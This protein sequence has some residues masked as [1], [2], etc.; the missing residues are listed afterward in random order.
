MVDLI[1]VKRILRPRLELHEG[2]RLKPY[3]D[4]R[5]FLTIGIGRNLDIKGISREEAD[6]LLGND[7]V[8]SI[9]LVRHNIPWSVNLDPQR[10]SVLVEMAFQMGVGGLLLFRKFLKALEE[11]D[12]ER[13][14]QE[15]LDSKW[16]RE[17]SPKRALKL[18]DIIRS[19]KDGP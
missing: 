13:A 6:I 14:A 18:F 4:S 10:F 1:E 11:G 16:A 12:Y 5:G 17:D 9:D 15:M 8:E 2:V 19:G 3:R 7:I